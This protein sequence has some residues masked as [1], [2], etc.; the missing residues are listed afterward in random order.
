MK[1]DVESEFH[2]RQTLKLRLTPV[3]AGARERRIL[4]PKIRAF[5]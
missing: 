5:D 3:A 1:A 2:V 4:K